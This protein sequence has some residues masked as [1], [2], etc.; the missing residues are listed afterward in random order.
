MARTVESRAVSQYATSPR[1]PPLTGAALEGVAGLLPQ[2]TVAGATTTGRS[3]VFAT[4]VRH[5]ELFR[6][7]TAMLEVL[8]NGTLPARD[9]ELL[10]L[11]TG[12]NCGSEYEWG[13]HVVVG[14]RVGLTD[15]EIERVRAGATAPD[16][17]DTTAA[18]LRAADELHAHATLSDPTW[19]VLS[20]RYHEQQLIEIVMVVGH[21]HMIAMLLK[22]LQVER[23][24][25]IPGFD[26]PG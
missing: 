3:N 4:L 8:L 6:T 24:P 14:R 2:M 16:W 12:W 25:G 10:I 11:R 9:R 1:I 26:T 13:Q 15:E 19:T 18:L 22:S 5:P 20:D 17:D 23:D 7:W 21:Y